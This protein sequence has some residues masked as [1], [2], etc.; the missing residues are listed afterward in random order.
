MNE[1]DG[2]EALRSVIQVLRE[3]GLWAYPLYGQD[4]R[5]IVACDTDAG[6]VDVRIGADGYRVEVWDV[7]PGL[8]FDEEDERRRSVKERLVRLTLPRL[9][10]TMRSAPVT[11]GEELLSDVWWDHEQHGIGIR[12]GIEI[13]FSSEVTLPHLI[14]ELLHQ[15]DLVRTRIEERLLE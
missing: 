2:R 14:Q 13:P 9:A 7:S 15:L 5:W 10:E 4:G 8:F 3:A 11:L 12:L 1:R 6:R